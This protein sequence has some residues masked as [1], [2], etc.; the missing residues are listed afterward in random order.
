MQTLDQLCEFLGFRFGA[1]QVARYSGQTESSL[2]SAA[3]LIKRDDA[4]ATPMSL[5]ELI[6]AVQDLPPLN[7]QAELLSSRG[8]QEPYTLR[9]RISPSPGI[10]WYTSVYRING[11]RTYGGDNDHLGN[12]IGAAGGDVEVTDL[13]PGTWD[14]FVERAGIGNIGLT[15]LRAN[16]GKVAVSQRPGVQPPALPPVYVPPSPPLVTC[17]VEIDGTMP[18]SGGIKNFRVYGGG[19]E[20]DEPVA[21]YENDVFWLLIPHSDSLG[22]WSATIGLAQVYPYGANHVFY[23]QG[24]RSHRTSWKAA[25]GLV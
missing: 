10:V 12:A 7:L 15:V 14:L 16:L 4:Y 24:Q 1:M 19:M 9:V 22:Q 5:R 21:V 20:P 17:Q 25:T 2:E 11:G 6:A 13:G 23:A 18:Q 3:L 8:E